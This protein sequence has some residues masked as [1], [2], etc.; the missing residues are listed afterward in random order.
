MALNFAL[1]LKTS[2]NPDSLLRLLVTTAIISIAIIIIVSGFSFYRVFSGFVIRNAETDSIHLCNL[3]IDQHQDILFTRSADNRTV[4]EIKESEFL[5]FDRNLRHV[6]APYQILKVKIYDTGKKIVYSTEPAL[7]GRVDDGNMRLDNALSGMVD[8]KMETKEDAHDLKE[9]RLFDV[10]VV[11]TYVPIMSPDNRVV[12][13]FEVYMNVTPYRDQIRKG[14]AV[15]TLFLTLIVLSVFGFSFLLIRS[16]TSQLKAAQMQLEI[17]ACTDPLTGLAN[18]HFFF[19]R[20]EEEFAKIVRARSPGGQ[21]IPPLCCLLID[22]DF[23]KTVNDSWGHLAGDQILKAVAERLEGSV[24][25]YDITGRYGGEE[26]AVLLPNTT[27]EPGLAIAERIQERIGGEHF[28]VAG[29]DVSLTVSIGLACSIATDDS[30]TDLLRRA[31]EGLYLAKG[32]G[33]DRIAWV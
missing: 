7:I 21:S 33:R 15:T 6:L 5:R 20:G 27:F 4:L 31:D 14:G 22:V 28:T 3:L 26:F 9:E 1:K 8:A 18:R 10:D 2:D 23:F 30:L 19:R 16:G 29:A 32:K 25:P 17:L 12:G 11:E 13:S 24:R